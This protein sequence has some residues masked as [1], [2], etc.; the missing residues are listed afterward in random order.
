MAPRVFTIP[1]SA[2]FLP[3]L[4]KALHRGELGFELGDPAVV[5]HASAPIASPVNVWLTSS[6]PV[7]SPKLWNPVVGYDA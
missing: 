3:T 7:C 2:P 5:A 6:I 4:I 1:A